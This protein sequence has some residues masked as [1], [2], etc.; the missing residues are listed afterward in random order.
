[1]IGRRSGKTY[2]LGDAVTVKLIEAAPVAGAVRFELLSQGRPGKA[3][4]PPREQR[5]F[6]YCPRGKKRN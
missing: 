1:M 3:Q 5:K 2:R 4:R 6:Q